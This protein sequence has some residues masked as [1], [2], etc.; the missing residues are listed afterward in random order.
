MAAGG[1]GNAGYAADSA[2]EKLEDV[3][4][5]VLASRLSDEYAAG[6]AYEQ[7]EEDADYWADADVSD[8]EMADARLNPDRR[9]A[10]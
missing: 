2:Y 1:A 6:V 9:E 4:E 7:L 10:G 5:G 8:D 3:T